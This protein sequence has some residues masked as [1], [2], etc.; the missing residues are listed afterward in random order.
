MRFCMPAA[1]AGGGARARSKSFY[2]DAPGCNSGNSA[3]ADRLLEVTA[4]L[5]SI[6]GGALADRRGAMMEAR[7]GNEFIRARIDQGPKSSGRGTKANPK[8][9]KAFPVAGREQIAVA[10]GLFVHRVV[11][12]DERH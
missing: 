6:A 11:P 4:R 2:F 3:V 7:R 12:G 8:K 5:R 10:T 9:E 1:V